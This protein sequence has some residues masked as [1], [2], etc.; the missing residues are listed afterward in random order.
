M[1][2]DNPQPH[3]NEFRAMSVSC[4]LRP[5]NRKAPSVPGRMVFFPAEYVA[6]PRK[7]D[8]VMVWK[9][10]KSYPDIFYFHKIPA[11]NS[12][13]NIARDKAMVPILGLKHNKLVTVSELSLLNFF[14]EE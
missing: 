11:E 12:M 13:V 1:P 5:Q 3:Q 4:A 2:Q 8:G 6:V 9:M 10:D 14:R 7:K